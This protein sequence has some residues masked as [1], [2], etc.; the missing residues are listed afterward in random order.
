MKRLA[1]EHA[2]WCVVVVF[3]LGMAWVEAAGV[4]YLRVLVDRV[5]KCGAGT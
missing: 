4:Y 3:A 5:A 2:R 1:R